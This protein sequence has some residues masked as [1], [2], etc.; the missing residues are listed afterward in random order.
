MINQEKIMDELLRDLQNHQATLQR[1]L[2]FGKIV[3][4][5][6]IDSAGFQT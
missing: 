3:I 4:H 5:L 1:R 6:I 2:V